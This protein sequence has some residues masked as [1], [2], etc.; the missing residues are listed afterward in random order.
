MLELE[1]L[2]VSLALCALAWTAICCAA[3]WRFV[4]AV[5]AAV[6]WAA[7]NGKPKEQE[8]PKRGVRFGNLTTS[9]VSLIERELGLHEDA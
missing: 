8:A 1:F 3:L 6:L 2:F 9:D 7:L 5:N 4:S